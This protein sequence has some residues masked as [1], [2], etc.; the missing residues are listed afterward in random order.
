MF[1]IILIATEH[2]LIQANQVITQYKLE[3]SDYLIWFMTCSNT[4]WVGRV[5]KENEFKNFLISESWNFSELRSKSVKVKDFFSQ[6]EKIKSNSPSIRFFFSQ[7]SSDFS[8][9]A[10]QILAPK[11]IILLDE[12]TASFA[13]CARRKKFSFVDGLKMLIKSIY[14]KKI[15]SFPKKIIF[16]SQYDLQVPDGDSF[17]KYTFTKENNHY[18]KFNESEV[19]FLGSS[20]V[21]VD[22]LN[23]D[24]Y[25]N[26]MLLI[27]SSFPDRKL[28]Y[29]PHRKEDKIK[30]EKIK[31]IGFEIKENNKPFEFFFSKLTVCPGTICSFFSPTIINLDSKY[32]VI[33]SFVIYKFDLSELKFNRDVV[34]K[35]YEEYSCKT[36]IKLIDLF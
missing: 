9:C 21:E 18:L 17:L 35:I 7:Y 25:L 34:T 22:L 16:F 26:L 4:D 19:A 24:Y 33:P 11:E 13:I 23:I 32:M 20:L 15:I 14:Y 3:S 2:H 8:L 1:N 27:K 29:F 36:N 10:I 5:V 28:F 31:K 30:I 6:L 12:G